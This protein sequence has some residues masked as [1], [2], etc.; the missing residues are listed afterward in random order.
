MMESLCPF[1]GNDFHPKECGVY[2]YCLTLNHPEWFVPKS[3][4]GSP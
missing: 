1:H 2:L 3:P 4:E